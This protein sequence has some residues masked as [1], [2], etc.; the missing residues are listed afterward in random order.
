KAIDGP[1]PC[2]WDPISGKALGAYQGTN[3]V[4]SA[5][6]AS[7]ATV[8]GKQVRIWNLARGGEGKSPPRGT[9]LQFLSERELLVTDNGSYRRWDFTL[10]QETFAT[11]KG[12]RGLALSANGRL[13]VLYGR[14][15]G[16]TREAILVWDLIE[17]KQADSLRDGGFAPSSASFSP[18]DRQL[19]LEDSSGKRLT[20]LVWDLATRSLINRLSS[21]GLQSSQG[22]WSDWHTWGYPPPS[23]SPDGAFLAA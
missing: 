8:T 22:P 14:P 17:G 1:V 3:P 16:Q 15:A 19:A 20:I 4:F 13:A 18:D 9:P 23:F 11:P 5:D 10:G 7:L 2:L 12:L 6:G 21:R